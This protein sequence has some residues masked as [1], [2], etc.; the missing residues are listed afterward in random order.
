MYIYSFGKI[1]FFYFVV[2]ENLRFM[3]K[4]FC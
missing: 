3:K 4:S 1:K 2:F